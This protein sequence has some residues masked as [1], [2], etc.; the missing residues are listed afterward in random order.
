M[1]ASTLFLL[2]LSIVVGAVVPVQSGSNA[3]LARHVGHPLYAAATNTALATLVLLVAMLFY[4]MPMPTFRAAVV[5]AP[6]WSW[7]GGIYGATLVFS[8]LTQAPRVGATAFVSA[9]LFGTI[10]MSLVVDHFGL[11]AFKSQPIT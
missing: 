8:A 2:L 9:T 10:V 6:W 3:M 11:L 5:S 1:F 7:M 4:K